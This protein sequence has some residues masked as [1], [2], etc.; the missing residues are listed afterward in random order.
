[1]IEDSATFSRGRAGGVPTSAC[2]AHV[3][4]AS[5][6]QLWF[7]LYNL[8]TYGLYVFVRFLIFFT[9]KILMYCTLESDTLSHTTYEAIPR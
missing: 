8:Y 6:A 2:G 4:L 1:M 5:L 7:L 3:L 9:V